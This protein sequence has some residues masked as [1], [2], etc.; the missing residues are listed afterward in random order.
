[1]VNLKVRKAK[2]SATGSYLVSNSRSLFDF[3]KIYLVLVI[4]S[5]IP[6]STLYFHS[7][8]TI[9]SF[10]LHYFTFSF[11]IIAFQLLSLKSSPNTTAS[12]KFPIICG[13]SKLKIHRPKISKLTW[14]HDRNY[15]VFIFP[16]LGY[17]PHSDCFQLHPS[18]V[19]FIILFFLTTE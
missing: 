6:F 9:Q 11:Y 8:Q 19:N 13:Y 3:F 16:G 10:L 5:C 2:W 12:N 17:H 4:F 15:V 18:T 1:M 14:R 7:S